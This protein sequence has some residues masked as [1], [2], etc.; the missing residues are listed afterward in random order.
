MKKLF[1]LL[2]GLISFTATSQTKELTLD[3]AVLGYYKGLYPENL[4][5]LQWVKNSDIFMYQNNSEITF[6]NIKNQTVNKITKEDFT[7]VFSERKRLPYVE[8]VT[9]EFIQFSGENEVIL[10]DYNKKAYQTI[11]LPEGAENQ[12]FG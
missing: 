8:T 5:N 11:K 7:S 2:I 6:K 4:R 3:D 9:T 10:Y 1:Y 12:D